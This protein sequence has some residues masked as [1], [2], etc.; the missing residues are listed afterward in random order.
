[1]KGLTVVVALVLATS[2]ALL[3]AQAAA[4][5]PRQTGNAQPPRLLNRVNPVYPR[6][7]QR[8]RIQ[9]V[10]RLQVVIEADG[11]VGDAKVVRS[12]D[13]RLDAAAME[14]VKQWR[15][16]AATVDGTPVRTIATIMVSFTLA[17]APPVLSWP[18]GF[19][20]TAAAPIGEKWLDDAAVSSGLEFR[21]SAPEG[22]TIQK[23]PSSPVQVLTM[24]DATRARTVTVF[25]PRPSIVTLDRPTPIA[26]LQ[27]LALALQRTAPG[28]APMEEPL[29]GQTEASFGGGYWVWFETDIA[30]DDLAKQGPQAMAFVAQLYERIHTWTFTATVGKQMVMVSCGIL[31]PRGPS[32][33]EQDKQIRQA[34]GDFGAIMRRISIQPAP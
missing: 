23:Q 3:L 30:T 28:G 16:E 14:A 18:E 1:V 32:P 5:A 8:E 10:V 12:L 4:P 34:A 2:H 11:S 9:G 21:I 17:G 33:E 20:P 27:R 26:E 25:V 31:V 7:V 29:S 24:R 6:E 13:P 22:W 15:Y 19:T